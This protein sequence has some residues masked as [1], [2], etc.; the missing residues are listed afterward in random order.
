[1]KRTSAK[2]G[3]FNA[4]I[5]RRLVVHHLALAVVAVDL[6]FAFFFIV[7]RT[8]SHYQ[9]SLATAYVG[10]LFLAVTLVI[11]PLNLLLHLRNPVSSDLRRDIG[12]W[13]AL[14]GI[15]H[16]VVSLPIPAVNVIYFFVEQTGVHGDLVPLLDLFGL[17]NYAGLLATGLALLLL[18]IANDWSLSLLGAK[19]WK[20]LQR[21]SYPLFALVVLHGLGYILL[22]HRRP[23]LLTI[24][25]VVSAGVVLLQLAGIIYKRYHQRPASS[26]TRP[27][28]PSPDA[29]I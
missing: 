17:S 21:W 12:I 28:P 16:V 29:M 4:R 14:L 9:L 11:G 18:L 25:I 7:P 19:R 27:T 20:G 1:M 5:R 22:Q 10:L 24:F 8:S 6:I 2:R 15:L 13:S 26:I 3:L 23:P